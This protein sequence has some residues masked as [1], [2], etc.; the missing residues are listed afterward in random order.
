MGK[1]GAQEYLKALNVW[2][3]ELKFSVVK[4]KVGYKLQNCALKRLQKFLQ[5]CSK[6]VGACKF[7]NSGSKFIRKTCFLRAKPYA[8]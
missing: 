1:L 4:D 6:Y 8:V 7:C 5:R 2:A 3:L